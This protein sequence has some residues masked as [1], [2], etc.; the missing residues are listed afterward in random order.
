MP[1][2]NNKLIQ[3][4]QELTLFPDDRLFQIYE[5][6]TGEVST[7]RHQVIRDLAVNEHV[8]W[9]YETNP[10]DAAKA[11]GLKDLM[12][13]FPKVF[14]K[15]WTYTLCSWKRDIDRV[16]DFPDNKI[17]FFKK[18]T[19]LQADMKKFA[20]W[21]FQLLGEEPTR[22]K[23]QQVAGEALAKF[24]DM[25]FFVVEKSLVDQFA[26]NI[27]MDALSAI[28]ND[29]RTEPN[30]EV[31]VTSGYC[32]QV[33]RYMISIGEENA[34]ETDKHDPSNDVHIKNMMD[35]ISPHLKERSTP[36][37]PAPPPPPAEEAD[38]NE[39]VLEVE[40]AVIQT[41][42]LEQVPD[43]DAHLSL[44]IVSDPLRTKRKEY[45]SANLHYKQIRTDQ[46]TATSW[47]KCRATH[48]L[49]GRCAIFIK[50][51]PANTKQNMCFKYKE[52]HLCDGSYEGCA[53]D[54]IFGHSSLHPYGEVI[55]CCD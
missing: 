37:A 6:V 7:N 4:F 17:V 9:S 47:K 5:Q 22:E 12:T 2:D 11:D 34:R 1:M 51:I 52:A 32:E 49:T 14:N 3:R 53:F 46:I 25:I 27:A 35:I 48:N 18:P 8:T 33:R 38:P 39:A 28:A 20:D 41:A 13:Y 15:S 23:E 29:P 55:V 26:M 24:K 43:A 19:N 21:F 45:Q 42:P 31:C 10:E 44:K 54:P 40:E 16:F 36:P 30:L 50:R